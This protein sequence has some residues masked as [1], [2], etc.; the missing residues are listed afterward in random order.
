[1]RLLD[2]MNWLELKVLGV[3]Y[4]PSKF[5]A[6]RGYIIKDTMNEFNYLGVGLSGQS[7]DDVLTKLL[8]EDKGEIKD[9]LYYLE[10]NRLIIEQS[11]AIRTQSY[12]NPVHILD[13][14]LT[15]KGKDFV[16]FI[17]LE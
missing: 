12:D 17:I 5:N 13:N 8:E 4:N 2:G 7:I 15:A 14:M 3:L 9:A 10:M 11:N 16:G 1:M 6:E